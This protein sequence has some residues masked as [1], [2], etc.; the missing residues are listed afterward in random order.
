MIQKM[1]K[2][3]SWRRLPVSGALMCALAALLPAAPVAAQGFG[4]APVLFFDVGIGANYEDRR[5]QDG[6]FEATTR[7]GLGLFTS[8]DVQRLSFETGI[9]ARLGENGGDLTDPFVALSWARFNRGAEIGVEL[10]FRQSQVDGADL[11]DDFGAGDLER[12]D[13]TQEDF[14]LALSL[15]TGR[16]APFGT[17]TELRYEQRTFGGA[18][19]SDDT[20]HAFHT[21][22]PSLHDRSAHR[23]PVQRLSAG[24]NRRRHRYGAHGDNAGRWR[25]ISTSTGSG[26]PVRISAL[27]R[28]RPRPSAA[29]PSRRGSRPGS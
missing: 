20:P 10:S 18:A 14:D 12:Q 23:A 21:F 13:G 7:V 3:T 9:T 19:T 29:P 24:G 17:Q 16:D 2:T 5:N 6:E 4:D 1:K 25:A 28:S 22:H 26:P 11:D 15:I 27:P 8:T